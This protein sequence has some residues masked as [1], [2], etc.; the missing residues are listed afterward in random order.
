FRRR[1][2]AAL[3]QLAGVLAGTVGTAEVLAEAAGLELHLT[4]AFVAFDH[5][6]IIALD[7]ELALFH[8]EA[9]AIGV[10]AAHVQLAMLIDQVA[11]HGRGANRAAALGASDAGLALLVVGSDFVAGYQVDGRL[12]A[13]LRRQ[14]VARATEK[15]AGGGGT[16]HHR[17]AA[18]DAGD[19]G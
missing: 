12:A 1:R 9:A 16:N 6:A 4:A 5:R 18:L 2:L 11:V 15:P 17:P 7:L 19:I 3:Q 8:L 13:L 10:V 14:G